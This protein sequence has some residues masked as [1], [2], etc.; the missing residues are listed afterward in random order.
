M[1]MD[2][3]LSSCM[4]DYG[5]LHGFWLYAFER[6]NGILGS[7]PNNN[8]AIEIQLMGRFLRDNQILSSP[9]PD[10]FSCDFSPLFPKNKT[11]V[12]ETLSA[13]TTTIPSSIANH[14]M[15]NEY[16]ITFPKHYT[17][18]IFVGN[19]KHNLVELY[20][21]LYS[22]SRSV[23]EVT[24]TYFKYSSVVINGKQVGSHGSRTKSSS[25][26]MATWNSELFGRSNTSANYATCR[27]A[28]VEYFCKHAFTVNGQSK[29]STLVSLSWFKIHPKNTDFGK[30][31]TVWY[32]DLFEPDGISN[33][34]EQCVLKT[35]IPSF[36]QEY[37]MQRTKVHNETFFSLRSHSIQLLSKSSKVPLQGVP[38][39]Y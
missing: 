29:F 33:L 20:I 38:R 28:R 27:A 37:H 31:V 35:H 18:H 17:R 2:C 39:S 23:F 10:D 1:H 12:S 4:T 19:Q 21:E 26:V 15:L 9:L 34:D 14:N 32:Y 3:H 24:S 22:V 25:V 6:Y 36:R 16:T 11:S 5:P 8:R 30:P 7:M 13:D